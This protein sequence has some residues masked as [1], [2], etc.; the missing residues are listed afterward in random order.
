M[1]EKYGV[2]AYYAKYYEQQLGYRYTNKVDDPLSVAVIHYAGEMKPWM[3]HWS[4][5]S[6]LKQ[7]L[8]LAALRLIGKRNTTTVLLEYKHLV[9]K[10]RKLLYAK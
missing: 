8:Q 1:G 5:L 6:V 4:P 2:I 10:A 3:Q 9:R 7:E